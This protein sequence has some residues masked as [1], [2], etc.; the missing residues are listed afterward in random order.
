MPPQSKCVRE[1]YTARKAG[2]HHIALMLLIF[3]R[4]KALI[5]PFFLSD[6]R[7]E[8]LTKEDKMQR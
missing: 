6:E 7:Q 4:V 5:V 3:A 2:A 1:Q 8:V